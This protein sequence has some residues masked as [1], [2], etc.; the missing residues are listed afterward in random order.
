M[1]LRVCIQLRSLKQKER[2]SYLKKLVPGIT[3]GADNAFVDGAYMYDEEL[4]NEIEL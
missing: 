1:R 4:N 2:Y 3:R